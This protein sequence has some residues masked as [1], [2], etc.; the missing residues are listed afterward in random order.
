MPVFSFLA[1]ISASVSS[2]FTSFLM[3]LRFF[4]GCIFDFFTFLDFSR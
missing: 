4:L 2:K 3:L 1:G